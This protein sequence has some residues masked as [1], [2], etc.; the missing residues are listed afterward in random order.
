MLLAY[1]TGDAGRLKDSH[2]ISKGNLRG[3]RLVYSDGPE[4][5]TIWY[6]TIDSVDE[7]SAF[8]I[9][10]EDLDD[11]IALLTALKMQKSSLVTHIEPV[12]Q[13]DGH[14]E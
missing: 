14:S 2:M 3:D 1:P 13:A 6:P 12:D 11:A 9:D 7:G 4:G 5:V 8:D 10:I